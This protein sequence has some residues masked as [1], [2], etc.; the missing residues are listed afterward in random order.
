MRLSRGFATLLPST[1]NR[2]VLLSFPKPAC[3]GLL[4]AVALV[5]TALPISCGEQR[6]D[7]PP[8][9]VAPECPAADVFTLGP[10][11][12]GPIPA[13]PPPPTPAIL[14]GAKPGSASGLVVGPD[15][16][17]RFLFP[18]GTPV[19]ATPIPAATPPARPEKKETP[20]PPTLFPTATPTPTLA[21]TPTPA[22]PPPPT[23]PPTPT[24]TPPPVLTADIFLETD[25]EAVAAGEKFAVTVRIDAGNTNS[26]DAAQVYLDFDRDKLAAVSILFGTRLEYQLQSEMDNGTG[27]TACAAGTLGVQ[28]TAPFTLCSVTFR[29]GNFAGTGET[30]VRFSPLQPPHWTKTVSRGSNI[31][32]KLL[33]VRV[34][35]R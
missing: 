17:S 32:G 13:G 35:L 24:L 22:L 21:P 9:V 28:A 5:L 7:C 4:L 30:L 15:R 34:L 10:F 19:P 23:L 18:T 3:S 20:E 6:Q 1:R 33:P 12:L 16:Q 25:R 14:P 2:P 8:G 29:A 27:R 11:S 26:V 31:T